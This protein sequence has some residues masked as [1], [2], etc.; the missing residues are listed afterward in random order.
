M[1]SLEESQNEMGETPESTPADDERQEIT[2]GAIHVFESLFFAPENNN[3]FIYSKYYCI[4]LI[5]VMF[6]IFS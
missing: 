4:M 5:A 2:F 1:V 6:P 3:N